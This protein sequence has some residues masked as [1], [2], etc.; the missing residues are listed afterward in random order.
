[1]DTSSLIII[2]MLR[3]MPFERVLRETNSQLPYL[4][5]PVGAAMAHVK[6]F[7]GQM[8]SV[9][10]A[11]HFTASMRKDFPVPPTP[12]MNILSGLKS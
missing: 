8:L 10:E 9:Y 6:S 12:L 7:E 11:R 3:S 1:M 5:N 2:L 4:H